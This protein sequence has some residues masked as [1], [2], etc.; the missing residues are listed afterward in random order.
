ML[1]E[2]K[3]MDEGLKAFLCELIFKKRI[4]I[5]GEIIELAAQDGYEETKVNKDLEIFLY[6]ILIDKVQGIMP[7][8]MKGD[9]LITDSRTMSLRKMGICKSSLSYLQI[10]ILQ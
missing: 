3:N 9:F 1:N 10:I 2:L 6:N 5:Q 7:F 4:N 8:L